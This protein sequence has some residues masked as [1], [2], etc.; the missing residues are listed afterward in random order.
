MTDE[1]RPSAPA[2]K[3]RRLV[4][5]LVTAAVVL[6]F[7]LLVTA[8]VALPIGTDWVE[9][10]SQYCS[11][12][13]PGYDGPDHLPGHE[14]EKC[15]DCHQLPDG[16]RIAMMWA[17]IGRP[18]P[19]PEHSSI[20]RDSCVT[21]HEK[22][23]DAWRLLV[24]NEG[25]RAHATDPVLLEC[26]DCHSGSLHAEPTAEEACM[27][28]HQD[29]PMAVDA[30]TDVDCTV[31]HLFGVGRTD[32]EIAAGTPGAADS[33]QSLVWSRRITI[34]SVHGAADCRLCH[35]PHR[36]G[37]AA[38]SHGDVNCS[39]CHRGEVAAS[40][41]VGPEQHR[42]CNT[43]HGIHANREQPSTS[44]TNCH[45]RPE[46]LPEFLVEE[47]RREQQ[48][49]RPRT[50]P[51][52][53][54]EADQTAPEGTWQ[55]VAAVAT[56]EELAQLTHQ[57][58]CPTCHRPHSWTANRDE[59]RECHAEQGDS[60]AAMP[61][62]THTDCIFC[63]E[64]HSPPP[65]NTT[66]ANCH[67]D[68]SR[69]AENAPGR[70]RECLSCHGPHRGRPSFAATC[71]ECHG[72]VRAGLR[73]GPDRHRV[74]NSCHVAHGNP[75]AGAGSACQRC[76][77]QQAAS[78][79]RNREHQRCQA[80]HAPHAFSPT[81]AMTRCGT[82]HAASARSGGP[83][84][85]ECSSCHSVH[86]GAGRGTRCNSCH[87]EI[88]P[89]VRGHSQCNN[90]HQPHTPA[91]GALSQ[92]GS[93]HAG[94]VGASRGWPAGSAHAGNCA[95]CHTRH[96]ETTKQPCGSCHANKGRDHT[97]PHPTC[98]GCHAPHR[99]PPGRATWW[100]R[101]AEC[102]G[103]EARQAARGG[104]THRQCQNCHANPGRSPTPCLSCHSAIPR[105][106]LHGQ[107]EHRN[108][109]ACH[110]THG[111]S[112]PRRQDCVRCHT[113]KADHFADA[114]N[115]YQCHEFAR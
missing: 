35:N 28:C 54:Q 76:H 45:A 12:C 65:G 40:A 103:D 7:G 41:A 11:S 50:R 107:A 15:Q 62:E 109:S 48:R 26:V 78:V 94:Q 63:H 6:L 99:A 55:L 19:M 87:S 100:T 61:P 17:G 75:A 4:P 13:H 112:M 73:T 115:C 2:P 70:H 33:A 96:D 91:S 1:P 59:C 101:C 37:P 92:C 30:I 32:E 89:T 36:T 25:H 58:R 3:P 5:K 106:L 38:G 14:D 56:P 98:Q 97:G 71:G 105:S 60:I 86:S 39:R 102:H 80:C 51:G 90:C 44:C 74:C 108:C 24:R 8:G 93:C 81:E 49:R 10:D 57:G 42:Q 20:Q 95:E 68:K 85:G 88:R 21:C 18:S 46:I 52:Q 84:R 110:A 23:E 82:C 64:P 67:G 43:C 34:D 16:E 31:C 69:A 29:V 72:D 77:T 53:P 79:A 111:R 113:D 83:H 47:R 104:T 114:P 66:C 9:A 22:D 27:H